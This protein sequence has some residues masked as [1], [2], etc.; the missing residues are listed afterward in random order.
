MTQKPTNST[1]K[2]PDFCYTQRI[3]MHSKT[4]IQNWLK[5]LGGKEAYFMSIRF[6]TAPKTKAELQKRCKPVFCRLFRKLLGRH[7]HKR[8]D[9]EFLLIGFKEVGS[10][11]NMHAHFILKA[12]SEHITLPNIQETLKGLSTVLKMDIWYDLTD[13]QTASKQYGDDIMITK[14]YSDGVYSYI[15]KE[16]KIDG[17]RITN[18]T[19]ILDIDL[20]SQKSKNQ[21]KLVDFS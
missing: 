6:K 5:K 19:I 3:A 1:Q 2:R 11:L 17:T 9:K 16:L 12:S 20:I 10:R 8:Y 15:T 14:I 21:I 4:E 18:D 13:K 7:W